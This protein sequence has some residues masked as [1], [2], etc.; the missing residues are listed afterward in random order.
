MK[1][2]RNALYKAVEAGGLDPSACN[3]D[4]GDET[5]RI[6]HRSSG[7]YFLLEGDSL[8]Y[9]ST[10]EI[11]GEGLTW[12]PLDH[13][14]W[15]TVPERVERWASEV[16][17]DA[18][19]PDLWGMLERD[20]ELITGAGFED[21]ANTPFTVQEQTEIAEKVEQVKEFVRQK[22][23]LDPARSV[24]LNAKLDN[25]EAAAGRIG[26]KDWQLL[27]Y[28]AMF[29]LIITGLLPPEA[30]KQVLLILLQGLVHLFGGGGTPPQLPPPM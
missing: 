20:Q 29:N 25:I 27:V 24:S 19:T 23:P 14:T 8:K 9:V 30:V 28:G 21:A 26:R 22:Y 13:F 1:F 11:G 17:R 6:T 5:T 10:Y 7:S 16:K 2:Q 12:G 18:D 4:F 3:I 15:P